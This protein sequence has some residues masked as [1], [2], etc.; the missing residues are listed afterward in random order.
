MRPRAGLAF[1]LAALLLSFL[2]S[3]P[4]AGASWRPTGYDYVYDDSDDYHLSVTKTY[5]EDIGGVLVPKTYTVGYRDS[6]TTL[7]HVTITATRLSTRRITGQ[8]IPYAFAVGGLA[9]LA[10]HTNM[11]PVPGTIP[12]P[13]PGTW[14]QR[15]YNHTEWHHNLTQTPGGGWLP[16]PDWNIEWHSKAQALD[17]GYPTADHWKQWSDDNWTGAWVTVHSS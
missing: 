7:G 12:G 15:G 4:P 6:Y 3:A 8:L 11:A 17:K 5:V 16:S 1:S 2:L 9:S 14:T 10:A 13:R